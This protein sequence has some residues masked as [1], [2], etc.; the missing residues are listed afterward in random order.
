MLYELKTK[1]GYQL[2]YPMLTEWQGFD[3]E[4][5]IRVK[6]VIQGYNSNMPDDCV[7]LD[8]DYLMDAYQKLENLSGYYLT[9]ECGVADDVGILAPL[10]V[11]I[12]QNEVHWDLDTAS[13][14][15]IL[16]PPYSNM[17]HSTLRLI[18]D[19]QQ[20]V[21]DIQQ[22]LK[23]LQALVKNGIDVSELKNADC[24]QNL[25]TNYPQ[26]KTIMVNNIYP[27]CDTDRL[28]SLTF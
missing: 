24:Y 27:N 6:P 16:I 23:H 22:L 9:C 28:L 7:V 26:V 12:S 8:I 15:D 5:N 13:Y 20:Y 19:K 14:Q 17:D 1:L 3:P 18:F 21:S 25:L 4:I 10:T 2:Y 11:H